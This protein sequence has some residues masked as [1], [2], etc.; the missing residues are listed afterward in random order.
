MRGTQFG[1]MQWGIRW[2]IILV[3]AMVLAMLG[4]MFGPA[5]IPG[6]DKALATDVADGLS[7]T[8]VATYDEGGAKEQVSHWTETII[9][10]AEDVE[11]TTC[12]KTNVTMDIPMVRYVMGFLN[13]QTTFQE[14]GYGWR[15]V[16]DRLNYKRYAEAIALGQVAKNDVFYRD[17][18]GDYGAPLATGESWTYNVVVASSNPLGNSTT[19]FST[20]VAS[21]LESVTV[22]AGTFSSCYKVVHTAA[23]G[24]TITEWWDST[25]EFDLATVKSVDQYNFNQVEVRELTDYPSSGGPTTY[26]L[27][28]ASGAGGSVT[29]PGEGPQGPYDAGTVVN[30][31]ATSDA[32]FAFDEWTGDT[33]D[34]ADTNAAS[35]TI[36]MNGD[37]SITANFS[38][39]A[40]QY[41]LTTASGGN[42]SV[43]TP[44]EGVFGPYDAGTSV[45]LV[46]TPDAGYMF[47]GWTGDTG[48]IADA[49]AAST[50]ITMN[51]EYSVT[52]N[53][54]ELVQYDLTTA[55]G[56]NGS[57]TTPGEGAF[58][59]YDGGTSVDLVA[60]PDAGYMFDGWTGDTGGIADANAASTTITMNG[61]YSITANF[62]ELVQFELTTAN[63]GNGTVT[64]PGEGVFSYDGGSVVNLVATS[65]AGYIFDRWTGDVGDVADPFSA[66]TTITMNDNYSVTADFVEAPEAWNCP[67]DHVALIAPYPGAGRAEIGSTI[68]IADMSFSGEWFMILELDEGSG[69]WNTY[70]SGFTTGNTLTELEPGKFYYVVVSEPGSLYL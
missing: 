56:D 7:W 55:S 46:A 8:H 58:G 47:N 22:P 5:G 45:D 14:P 60:S 27:D 42:G 61:D 67:I 24:K 63:S 11:G 69:A 31:V 18:A 3:A 32:G 50:T 28:T 53:F 29:D 2:R 36:T 16:S 41:G 20:T 23:N 44:G 15:G 52:A 65:N 26:N 62:V 19:A 48:D 68:Q 25:G 10:T 9:A 4:A 34:I 43:T 21:S 59:P 30:L 37:Y 49:A 13:I 33:G 35:T 6:I 1:I 57:V 12:Y 64:D 70:Y 17:Y 54:A 66:S 39:T 38:A 51:G 40:V